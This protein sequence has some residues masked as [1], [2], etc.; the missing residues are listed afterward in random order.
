M[1]IMIVKYNERVLFIF[2]FYI[3]MQFIVFTSEN[4]MI[5]ICFVHSFMFMQSNLIE[6]VTFFFNK[7]GNTKKKMPMLLT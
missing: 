1:N 6:S 2:H 7:I 3:Y 5:Q 4:S